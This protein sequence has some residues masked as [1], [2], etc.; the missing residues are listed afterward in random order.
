MNIDVEIA[1]TDDVILK[2]LE[3]SVPDGVCMS[4]YDECNRDGKKRAWALKSEWGAKESPFALVTIDGKPTKAF[5]TEAGNVAKDL[6]NY[7]YEMF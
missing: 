6:I 4:F 3:K 1:F 7:L 5:Y 2:L